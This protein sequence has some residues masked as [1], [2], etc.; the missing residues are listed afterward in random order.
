MSHEIYSDDAMF[1]T[2]GITPWHR[3][4][5]AT[6]VAGKVDNTADAVRLAGCDDPVLT[7]EA[8]AVL[9]DGTT[10]AAPM[11]RMLVRRGRVL[12]AV[13]TSY[14][15]LQDVRAFES[16]DPWVRKGVITLETAGTLRHGARMWI[17]AALATD[18]MEIGDGDVVKPYVLLTNSHGVSAGGPRSVTIT[19]T[20]VRAVC[21]NTL[22]AALLEGILHRSIPHFSNV[23]TQVDEAVASIDGIKR[24]AEQQAATFR[25]LASAE[26]PSDERDR[27]DRVLDYLAAVWRAE[28]A[29]LIDERGGRAKKV[30]DLFDGGGRGS[31]LATADGTYWGLYNALADYVTHAARGRNGDEGRAESSVFGAGADVLRRGIAVAWAMGREGA[32]PAQLQTMETSKIEST[33]AASMFA[34]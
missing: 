18:A 28:S 16:F 11:S 10:L 13:G 15:D 17:L 32:E 23:A 9:S 4:P 24:A 6:V 1:S 21:Q 14:T 30:A 7:C 20:S 8:Q 27:D 22:T 29:D 3:L 34:A 12:A 31:R 5:N 33:I 25:A 19:A 26:L 2:N